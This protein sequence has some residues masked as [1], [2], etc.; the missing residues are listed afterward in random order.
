[1]AD[2]DRF[3]QLNIR[4]QRLALAASATSIL[5]ATW[6]RAPGLEIDP[7]FFGA[8]IGNLNVGFAIV[9]GLPALFFLIAWSLSQFTKANRLRETILDGV[10]AGTHPAGALTKGEWLLLSGYSA[11][12]TIKAKTLTALDRG[13]RGFWLFA[14]PPISSLIVLDRYFDFLPNQS[15]LCSQKVLPS[16]CDAAV[17]QWGDWERISFLLFDGYSQGFRPV[18]PVSG[19]EDQPVAENLPWIYPVWESWLFVILFVAIVWMSWEAARQYFA[20]D[21][22][23]LL[24]AAKPD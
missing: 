13:I 22:K 16:F 3:E 10:S 18:L 11:D 24:I 2:I 14:M 6:V 7:P 4:N 12:E 23:G 17:K 15:Q 1:M 9:Y 8:K 20:A 21:L 5:L 19:I